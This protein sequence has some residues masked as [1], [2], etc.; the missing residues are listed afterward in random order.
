M[1]SK[2]LNRAAVRAKIAQL[3]GDDDEHVRSWDE[4]VARYGA[5]A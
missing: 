2:T 3:M 5:S 1:G 4:I